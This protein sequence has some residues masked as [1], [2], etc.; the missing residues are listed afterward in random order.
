MVEEIK[1]QLKKLTPCEDDTKLFQD[2][3]MYV[4]TYEQGK[5]LCGRD[6]MKQFKL[7]RGDH[8]IVIGSTCVQRFFE[9]HIAIVKDVEKYFTYR[10]D[11]GGCPNCHCIPCFCQTSMVIPCKHCKQLHPLG[12]MEDHVKSDHLSEY[13]KEYHVPCAQ[14]QSSVHFTLAE[15]HCGEDYI[16]FTFG[17]HSGKTVQE[18]PLDYALWFASLR[19]YEKKK[20][21]VNMEERR[22][23]L[24]HELCLKRCLNMIKKGDMEACVPS[25][26]DW[27]NRRKFLQSW[28]NFYLYLKQT[29]K[30]IYDD[31]NLNYE[32]LIE[33]ADETKAM[34]K[35]RTGFKKRAKSAKCNESA[36]CNDSFNKK[37]RR[38]Q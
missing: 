28:A 18:I 17:K 34:Y 13:H 27:S 19:D 23:F 33:R 11:Q 2:W 24:L 32:A 10:K 5:C 35:K 7:K 6:I 1:K 26:Q 30:T 38:L 15:T 31:M 14:C 29:R 16:T 3:N 8:E 36:K 12:Q 4:Y 21:T 20:K 25:D 9:K 22:K 37:K